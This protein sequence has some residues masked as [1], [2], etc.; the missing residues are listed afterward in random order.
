MTTRHR[1]SLSAA[2]N[3]EATVSVGASRAEKRDRFPCQ[4]SKEPV[5]GSKVLPHESPLLD[6]PTGAPI[7][8][9]AVTSWG[10]ILFSGSRFHSSYKFETSDESSSRAGGGAPFSLRSRLSSAQ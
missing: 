8:P 9:N 10:N 4:M 6:H 2:G 7:V 1:T 3:F 5:S